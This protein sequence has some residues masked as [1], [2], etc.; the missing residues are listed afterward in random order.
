PA[1]VSEVS[2]QLTLVNFDDVEIDLGV[3]SEKPA[4]VPTVEPVVIESE[5]AALAS[6]QSVE[7]ELASDP[8]KDKW[9]A[10]VRACKE[11]SDPTEKA[12][13][14]VELGAMFYNL[15]CDMHNL[16]P[17]SYNRSDA[18]KRAEFVQTLCGC[19]KS[20]KSIAPREL[21]SIFWLTKL[22][23]STE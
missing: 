11:F 1:E 4:A 8:L 12:A 5:E 23:R 22:D 3:E 21:I 6:V 17:S 18:I 2:H 15:M 10:F 13:R 16:A 20:D 7:T 9:I 19:D 14:V